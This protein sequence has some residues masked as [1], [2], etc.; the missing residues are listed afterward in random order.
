[1]ATRRELKAIA[2]NLVAMNAKLNAMIDVLESEYGDDA[3]EVRPLYS[4]SGLC[5]D[6]SARITNA[7]AS[8]TKEGH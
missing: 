7:L 6:A 1:M 8:R 2:R 3:D 4:A 5:L